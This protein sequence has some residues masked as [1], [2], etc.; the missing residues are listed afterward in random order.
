MKLQIIKNRKYYYLVSGFLF[1]A[2]VLAIIAWGLKPGLDFTGG[3]LLELS[4]TDNRPQNTEIQE[5]TKSLDL[6]EVII[7][8]SG[9]RNVILKF[10]NVNEDQHQQI[11]Q[12]INDKFPG[13]SQELRF[14]SIGPVIGQ[15]LQKKA[16][17]A[18]LVAS[19]CIIIYI[20]FAFRKVSKPVASWKYGVS[21]ILALIHDVTIVV[22]LFAVL[23]RFAGVEVDGLFITA[24]L[25]IMGF[26]VHDTIVVFDR[27]REN[28][29]RFYTGKFDEVVNDSVNQT[30]TRSI[31]TSLTVLLVLFCLYLFGGASTKNFTLALLVGIFIGTYSSIFI[32]SCLLLD[33]NIWDKKLKK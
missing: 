18:I 10:Q 14:E 7:Q 26:S 23:G 11:L 28:L 32:A 25:T 1:V 17:L 31:N 21:A 13:Q 29:G 27:T 3:S 12:S 8:P 4:F 33:W 6:G 19:L 5:A 16:W 2:S 30:V 24:L 9:D 22:G 15:E 20:A